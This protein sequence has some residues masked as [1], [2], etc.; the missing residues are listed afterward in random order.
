MLCVK[1]YES[2]YNRIQEYSK[3]VKLEGIKKS[4]LNIN[5][6]LCV[7]LQVICKVLSQR[8]FS[9]ISPN[10]ASVIKR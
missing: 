3:L 8:D 4:L 2:Q 9:V 1:I 6:S 7:P 5:I 10:Y